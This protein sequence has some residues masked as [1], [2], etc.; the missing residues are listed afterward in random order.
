MPEGELI[1][2]HHLPTGEQGFVSGYRVWSL[3]GGKQCEIELFGPLGQKVHNIVF[4][5][6]IPA[7]RQIIVPPPGQS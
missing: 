5:I 2:T 4:D 3:H 7:Q 1:T 6:E